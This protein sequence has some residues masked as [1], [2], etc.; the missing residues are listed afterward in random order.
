MCKIGVCLQGK[1][2]LSRHKG[3]PLHSQ[4]TKNLGSVYINFPEE[5][6]EGDNGD[7]FCK[8]GSV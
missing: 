8:G 7:G 6:G 5:E 3:V 2:H 1:V 4:N